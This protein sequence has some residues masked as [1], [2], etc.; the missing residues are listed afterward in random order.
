MS[1]IASYPAFKL[2][3][4]ENSHA[5]LSEYTSLQRTSSWIYCG[6]LLPLSDS[7][8][9]QSYHEWHKAAINGSLTAT[10]LSF[11]SF[12]NLFLSAAGVN[13]Y[14]L[15]IRATTP[16]T[17]YDEPRWH[18]DEDFFQGEK[19]IR[20][21]WKLVT[22]LLGPGTLFIEDAKT[23]RAVESKMKLDAQRE[24]TD[25]LCT[26][27]TC[28]G[29][30]TASAAVRQRLADNFRGHKVI[31]AAN[32]TCCFFRIGQEQ[33]A[34]HSEPPQNCDR[35]FVNIVPGTAGELQDLMAKWG[36][37]AFPRSW[38]IGLPMRAH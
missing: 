12:A 4:Y 30:A 25:H 21:Q 34:V 27:F 7:H 24:H 32:G 16:T 8:L 26:S 14:W 6:P 5:A 11:L 37:T 22:T 9:P 23:A 33:G 13:H 15:T 2:L 3:P 10:L 31:Q 29:C 1:N 35:V 38:S 18:T 28:L 20:T 19:L 17:D 36:M